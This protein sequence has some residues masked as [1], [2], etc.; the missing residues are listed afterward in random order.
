MSKSGCAPA[1]VFFWV[2]KHQIVKNCPR[3]VSCLVGDE[4]VMEGEASG[5]FLVGRRAALGGGGGGMS[6]AP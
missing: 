2:I 6:P 5:L 4:I 1:C 3:L